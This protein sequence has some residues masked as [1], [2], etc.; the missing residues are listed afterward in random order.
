MF[1]TIFNI[2]S[3]IV[4]LPI[5]DL[6]VKA[7]I[8]FIKDD[9]IVEEKRFHYVDELMLKTPSIAVQQ[10]KK[11]IINMAKIAID[12]F[13]ISIHII[14]THD[15]SDVETFRANEEELNYLNRNLVDLVVKLSKCKLS[16]KDFIYLNSTHR[17]ISDFERIGDY[18][19]NII[20]YADSMK[21]ANEK[22]SKEANKEI[23]EVVAKVNQLYELTVLVY[24]SENK[25]E[26][27]KAKR[28]EQ[29][30]DDLTKQ[31]SENHIIRMN[32][33][34]CNGN[35]GAQY[36]KLSSDIERIGDHL[37]NINDK[38]YELSH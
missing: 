4:V 31:M 36:L 35:V 7:A 30:I 26:F 13:N 8:S 16:Y 11:E 14:K 1:H 3:V 18:S 38:D 6:L 23:D 9:E 28:I 37:I 34:V 20:E 5:S 12:N 24:E 25:K 2:A 29:D 10:V 32:D 15:Y 27:K 33:G 19:E 22:F 17:A 21:E